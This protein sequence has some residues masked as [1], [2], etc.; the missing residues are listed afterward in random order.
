MRRPAGWPELD[1]EM[2]TT[3]SP[4]DPVASRATALVFE[5]LKKEDAR[6]EAAEKA[7]SK[8]K[9][10]STT[11]GQ[12]KRRKTTASEKTPTKKGINQILAEE[13]NDEDDEDE[14]DE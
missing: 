1:Y 11:V 13:G 10:K 7:R 3:K 8:Q 5:N 14:D 4:G 9:P 6:R 2:E 12:N